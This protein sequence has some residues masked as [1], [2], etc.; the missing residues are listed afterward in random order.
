MERAEIAHHEI[1]YFSFTSN[2]RC[3]GTP[4]G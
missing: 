4:F 3:A 2:G 1:E